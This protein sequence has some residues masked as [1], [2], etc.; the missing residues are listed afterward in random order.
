MSQNS[1]SLP[2]LSITTPLSDLARWRLLWI[3]YGLIAAAMLTSLL[4]DPFSMVAAVVGLLAGG[5]WSSI[6]ILWLRRRITAIRWLLWV[7]GTLAF[8]IA[9]VAAEF[10]YHS[11]FQCLSF[12]FTPFAF[13]AAVKGRALHEQIVASQSHSRP[14]NTGP[15]DDATA[16]T[17]ST[18]L[19]SP[20]SQRNRIT[21]SAPTFD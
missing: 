8:V 10:I 2:S 11:G 20:D 14:S 12:A 3:V 9:P 5:V 6:F 4:V 1:R 7:V 21:N 16:V 17:F 19:D 15:N 18:H 13:L